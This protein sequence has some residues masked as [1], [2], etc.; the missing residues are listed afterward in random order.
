MP[1]ETTNINGITDEMLQGM[2]TLDDVLPDFLRFIGDAVL[3]AHNANFD[4]SFVNAALK[5]RWEWARKQK[6]ED[7]SQGSLLEGLAEPNP[8]EAAGAKDGRAA[9]KPDLWAPPF[10]QLPNR[11]ADTLNFAKEAFPGL[12][13]YKMQDLAM[14]LKI[15]A[16]DAH[17]AED[18]A[19]VC[20]ELF[21]KCAERTFQKLS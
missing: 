15:Q 12:P 20:M 4:G 1:P 5:Q 6:K 19:R 14:F 8:S 9:S 17:R 3:I 10:A 2:P 16:L 21:I 18:D 11:V 13:K 7:A